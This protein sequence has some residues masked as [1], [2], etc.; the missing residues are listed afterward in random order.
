MADEAELFSL[1]D[2]A[3][4]ADEH[5]RAVEVRSCMRRGSSRVP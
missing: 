2:A 1:L 3:L 5:A 4:Q